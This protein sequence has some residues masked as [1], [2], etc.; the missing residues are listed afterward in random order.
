[1]DTAE[2]RFAAALD[3]MQPMLLNYSKGGISWREHGVSFEQVHARNAH[4]KNVSDELWEY[5]EDMLG[6]AKEK[7]C[8]AE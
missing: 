7:G 2:T 4:I 1:M 5:I 3:R 6:Q 8:F